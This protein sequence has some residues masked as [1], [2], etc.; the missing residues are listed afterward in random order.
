MIAA[1]HH[2]KFSEKEIFIMLHERPNKIEMKTKEKQMVKKLGAR[3]CRLRRRAN[4]TQEK[5][6]ELA[7][8]S[9]SFFASIERGKRCAHVETLRRIS[10]VLNTS[11]PEILRNVDNF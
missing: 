9:V 3:I 11:I 8:I 6:A 1:I 7:D 2:T 10:L 4:L 5:V